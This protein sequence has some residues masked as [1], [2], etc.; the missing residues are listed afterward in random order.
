MKHIAILSLICFCFFFSH[1]QDPLDGFTQAYTEENANGYISPLTDA[2]F[3]SLNTGVFPTS[4]AAEGLHIRV[5]V[6]GTMAFIPQSMKTFSATTEAP[7]RPE[8]TVEVPT[9]LGATDPVQVQGDNGTAYIF[10]TGFDVSSIPLAVPQAQIGNLFGTDFTFRYFAVSLDESIEDLSFFGLGVR[11]N[12]GRYF[13]DSTLDV[14]LAYM[15]QQFQVDDLIDARSNL[16]QV[17]VGQTLGIFSYYGVIGIVQ[18]SFDLQ[19]D[20]EDSEG[21]TEINLDLENNN[22]LKIGAGAALQASIVNLHLEINVGSPTTI[23]TGLALGL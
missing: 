13:P 9:V 22:N 2:F 7:F 17:Q 19:Y 5:G 20:H 12:F 15:Y 8:Q 1:A 6:V 21:T 3:T 4:N 14:N 10:P 18:G 11:H 16:I 23:A